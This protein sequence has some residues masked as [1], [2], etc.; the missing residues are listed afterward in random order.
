M[1]SFKTLKVLF[2]IVL[3]YKYYYGKVFRGVDTLLR[4]TTLSKSCLPSS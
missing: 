2:K 4:E 3:K 1:I